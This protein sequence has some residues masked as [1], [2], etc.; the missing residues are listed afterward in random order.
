MGGRIEVDSRLGRGSTF[1]LALPPRPGGRAAA[2]AGAAGASEPPEP[3]PSPGPAP[4]D[5]VYVED[6]PSNVLL[7]ERALAR[8]AGVRLEAVGTVAGALDRIRAVRPAVVLLDLDLPDG[9]GGEVLAA[10]RR[11]PATAALPVLV[12]SSDATDAA[13]GRLLAAGA[14][15]FITKP[16]DVRRLLD[17]VRAA[18]G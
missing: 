5:V 18:L 17:A 8:H 14:T 13:R 10:L 1:T 16:F 2:A 6:N 11:D 7:V 9:D 15:D 4:V 3:G 12:V